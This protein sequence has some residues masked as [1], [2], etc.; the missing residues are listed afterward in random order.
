[1]TGFRAVVA[2]VCLVAISGATAGC[3]RPFLTTTSQIQQAAAQVALVEL[4]SE[5]KDLAQR[6]LLWGAGRRDSAPAKNDVFT[7]VGIDKTGYSRGYDAK[8]ADGR[9]WDIKVGDEVQPE[10]VLSR[11]LWAVGYHQ[12]ETYYLAGWQL[13][14][15]WESEGE[16]ARFRL[17][18]DHETDGEW[19]WLDNP[20]GDTRP[21]HG[22]VAI[23][24]LLN[25]HDLKTSNNR[26]Y[27]LRDPKAEPRRRYIV[28][29]L[30]ASLGK[31][32]GFPYLRGTR[33]NIDDYEDLNLIRKVNGATVQLDYRGFHSDV[34]E[35][36]S[37]VD[38]IWACELM[39]RLSDAQLDDA[40]KAAEYPVEL[41]KRYIAKLR[42][43]IREGLALRT[44]QQR[45]SSEA[46]E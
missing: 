42:D 9:D 43:K 21:L 26:I 28:Q 17:Q 3:A 32:R 12:P 10:I 23:N 31:P 38:V 44:A 35:T 11:I 5:P 27:R 39:D 20:F 19:A 2:S 37:A 34:L 16:P 8:G 33:N 6:D 22:L 29:D 1:M 7:V 41:R 45:V 13:A 30:G 25:N 24:L 36:L 18:S 14:G 4:W 40:F 46:R 15:S